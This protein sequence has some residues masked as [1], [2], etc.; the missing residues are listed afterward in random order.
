[1]QSSSAHSTFPFFS[2]DL[3]D[4]I[5]KVDERVNDRKDL[6]LFISDFFKKQ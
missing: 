3:H 2:I 6:G 1:M 5:S 4:S